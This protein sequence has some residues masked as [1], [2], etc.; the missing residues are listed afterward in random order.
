MTHAERLLLL[1]STGYFADCPDTLLP[2]LVD[3]V[4]V[5]ADTVLAEHGRFCHELVIVASGVLETCRAGRTGVLGRASTFGWDAM[6]NRGVHD[7]TVRTVTAATLLVMSHRQFGTAAAI[8]GDRGSRTLNSPDK[9]SI[10]GLRLTVGPGYPAP[11]R[12]LPFEG[13]PCPAGPSPA[14]SPAASLR[15]QETHA[16]PGC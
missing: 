11:G 8:A 14:G 5:P 7:A 12:P 4:C 13:P 10:S 2:M 3:E 1:R 15:L 6:E 9:P 16:N